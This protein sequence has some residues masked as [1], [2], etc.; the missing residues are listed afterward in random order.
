[1]P[2]KL[3]LLLLIKRSS[4]R[5]GHCFFCVSFDKENTACAEPLVKAKADVALILAESYTFCQDKK[6]SSP[7]I[8]RAAGAY[9]CYS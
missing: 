3:S 2:K 6:A 1:M 7:S 9:L 4:R 8:F 5:Q